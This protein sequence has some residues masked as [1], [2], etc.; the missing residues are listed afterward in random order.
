MP[1]PVAKLLYPIGDALF[2]VYGRFRARRYDFRDTIV[3]SSSRQ[4]EQGIV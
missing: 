4:D 2:C 1:H 3:V